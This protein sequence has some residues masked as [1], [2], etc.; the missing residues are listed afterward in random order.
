ML[1]N[2][3][4]HKKTDG[5]I[6]FEKLCGIQSVESELTKND[7]LRK[8]S[9]CQENTGQGYKMRSQENTEKDCHFR[10]DDSGIEKGN[11]TDKACDSFA[12]FEF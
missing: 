9:E 1:E 4:R 3:Q 10:R 7:N 12:A 11:H 6:H 8:E 5:N 2:S